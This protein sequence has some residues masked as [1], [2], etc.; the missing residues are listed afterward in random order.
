M[1]IEQLPGYGYPALAFW[2]EY[3]YE[4]DK[5]RIK[6]YKLKAD[7]KLKW[8]DQYN[9]VKPDAVKGTFFDNKSDAL[10]YVNYE[11][12]N[13][14]SRISALA[15]SD[16]EK[17]SLK[18]K[19]N[20]TIQTKSRLMNEE[21]LMLTAAIKKHRYHSKP[22]YEDLILPTKELEFKES[23]FHQLNSMPYLKVA[24]VHNGKYRKVIFK[25]ITNEWSKTYDL[26]P[27]TFLYTER[28]KIANGFDLS[29]DSHWGKTKAIIRTKLLPIANQLLQLDSVKMLLKD[30]EERGQKV[31][32]SNGYVFWFEDHGNVGWQIKQVKET[33]SEN[34]EG[35]TIWREGTI[36]SKNHGRLVILPYIKESGEYVQGHTK[37]AP[38][39][40]PSKPRI[41]SEYVELPFEILQDDLMIGLFGELKYE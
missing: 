33:N 27:K 29:F 31:L 8:F 24:L 12:L 19:V 18:L 30:A 40:G 4:G 28:A 25:N 3:W 10:A 2:I 13:I 1:K 11:N 41:P 17:E 32:V 34:T 9:Q 14:N 20:K 37:N 26:T 36:I 22:A 38:H 39:D 5:W 23:L 16:V 21:D 15:L 7:G 6:E 35:H